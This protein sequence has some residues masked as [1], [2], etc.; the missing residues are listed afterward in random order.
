[1]GVSRT[2]PA[3]LRLRRLGPALLAAA[4]LAAGCG[5][6]AGDGGAESERTDRT[7]SVWILESEPARV[8]ATRANLTGFTRRTGIKVRLRGIGEDEIAAAV[9]EARAGGTLPDALQLPLASVHAYAADGLL[10]TTAAGD[11][12]GRLGDQTF[13]QTALS[14]VSRDGRPA[15]VPSDGWGQL[16]IYRKDLFAQ[17]GLRPP[18]TLADV[19]RA[20][21]RLNRPGQRAGITLATAPGQAFTAQ[22]FEHVALAAG[23]QVVDD[24]GRIRLTSPR[25]EEAFRFYVDLARRY[26]PRGFQDVDATRE[27]YFAGKAAMIFWSPFLLD[28]MAGL[29]DDAV[30]TCPQCRRDPAFLA[31][32]SGLVGALVRDDGAP[33]A[34]FGE[35]ASWGITSG[36]NADAAGRFVEYMLSD[37]YVRWLELSPQGKYPVRTGDATD[38]ERFATAWQRLKSGVE[39]KA[40]LRRFY[41]QASI[42]SL[43]EGV[44][45]F[46]RWGFQQG[47]APLMGALRNQEPITRPLALAVIGTIDAQTAARQAQLEVEAVRARTR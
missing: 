45:S 37:G 6:G 25:C 1:M 24:Q 31:K 10:D 16:L 22:T 39:R 43:G 12:I 30:P 15:A 27:T 14:L 46:Q 8:I 32:N 19:R 3:V 44:R 23:C 29:R 33:P 17:A 41:G 5:G 38:L 2:R 11:V 34:Q 28:A 35:L 13:S 7:I 26:S 9:S 36:P 42:D 21:A 20:A 4:L 47:E 18:R 40:P